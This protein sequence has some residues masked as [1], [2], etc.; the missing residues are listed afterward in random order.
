PSKAYNGDAETR[1]NTLNGIT[2][3]EFQKP[4]LQRDMAG[5]L[6]D[7]QQLAAMQNLSPW[8]KD[9]CAARIETIEKWTRIQQIAKEGNLADDVAFLE[10]R[11]A[12]QQEWKAT[13]MKIAELQRNSPPL[14]EGEL[15]TSN[16]VA[17]K[18]ALVDPTTGR[19]RAYITPSGE[20]DLSKLLGKNVAVYGTF[21]DETVPVKT[22]K[23]KGVR[24]FDA[25]PKAPATQP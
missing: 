8:I 22:I 9:S 3:A 18:Y 14:A 4:L 17:N 20:I 10:K 16:I 12:L 25:P 5:L 7:W 24:T 19:V 23:V 11:A 21:E 6:K 13:E 15:R 1:F 2:Q